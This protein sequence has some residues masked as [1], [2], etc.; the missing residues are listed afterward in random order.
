MLDVPHTLRGRRLPAILF[1]PRW[2]ERNQDV[3]RVAPYYIAIDD[4]PVVF[5]PGAYPEVE[6]DSEPS[7]R[8]QGLTQH[9]QQ[10]S[11][12]HQL[13]QPTQHQHEPPF[14]P[15]PP[16][17]GQWQSATPS[18]NSEYT[19]YAQHFHGFGGTQEHVR[20]LRTPIVF[21]GDTECA[22]QDE[23]EEEQAVMDQQVHSKRR[24]TTSVDHSPRYK[25][26]FAS[27]T[28]STTSAAVPVGSSSD[29]ASEHEPV[30]D[31]TAPPGQ[32]DQWALPIPL[33]DL[34]N[35][36]TMEPPTPG[37]VAKIIQS[38]NGELLTPHH[39]TAAVAKGYGDGGLPQGEGAL[40]ELTDTDV[41]MTGVEMQGGDSALEQLSEAQYHHLLQA[42]HQQVV[43]RL[44]QQSQGNQPS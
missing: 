28:P 37:A 7:H 23:E 29:R 16:L 41:A 38:L 35:N 32:S 26:L 13:Q 22:I 6:V 25:S 8:P 42:H 14:P 15:P 11:P 1:E 24:C 4:D 33:I 36:A 43:Q 44:S 34:I 18:H 19:E 5:T 12:S 10:A 2:L 3:L 39:S 30:L 40:M 31:T 27:S 21:G 17:H 9:Q 20:P